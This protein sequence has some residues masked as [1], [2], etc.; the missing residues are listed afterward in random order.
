[1]QGLGILQSPVTLIDG[2]IPETGFEVVVTAD[3]DYESESDDI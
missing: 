1:M 2:E 3:I